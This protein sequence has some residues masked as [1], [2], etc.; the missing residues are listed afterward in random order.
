MLQILQYIATD[1]R[2]RKAKING[3]SFISVEILHAFLA[4]AYVN[5]VK[6]YGTLKC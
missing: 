6:K 3:A 1:Y 2:L 4:I 5:L